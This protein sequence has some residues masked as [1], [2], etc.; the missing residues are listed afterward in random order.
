MKLVPGMFMLY[1][2]VMRLLRRW[3]EL[4]GEVKL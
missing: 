1:L 2:E 4:C 3:L